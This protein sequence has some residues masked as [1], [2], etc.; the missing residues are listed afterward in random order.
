MARRIVFSGPRRVALESFDPPPIEPGMV[1]VQAR[2]TLMST[3]AENIILNCR[4]VVRTGE[5]RVHRRT[6]GRLPARLAG[7]GLTPVPRAHTSERS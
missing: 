5:D 7:A 2:Y 4:A 1:A 3:G 6:R